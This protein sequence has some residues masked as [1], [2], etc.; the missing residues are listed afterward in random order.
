MIFR[1]Q[2]KKV[3]V[4]LDSVQDLMSP[5]LSTVRS[6]P[7]EAAIT[8]TERFLLILYEYYKEKLS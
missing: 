3:I 1:V 4:K 8:I 5:L 2:S 7:E 6:T